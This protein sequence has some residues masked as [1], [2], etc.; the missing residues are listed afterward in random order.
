MVANCHLD[1]KFCYGRGTTQRACHRKKLAINEWT[2][3]TPKVITVA[4]IK[5]LYGISLPVCVLLFQCLYLGPFWRHYHF[6]SEQ[7][8]L[9]GN[10]TLYMTLMHECTRG[11]RYSKFG[12]RSKNTVKNA[13]HTV[14]FGAFLTTLHT[15]FVNNAIFMAKNMKFVSPCEQISVWSEFKRCT[16]II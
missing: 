2:W 11:I 3:H 4:A 9:C 12:R 13:Q 1:K 15:N 5:W 16:A 8:C 10:L 7:D 6:W 14:I